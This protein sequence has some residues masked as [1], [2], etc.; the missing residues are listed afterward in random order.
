MDVRTEP[1]WSLH[2]LSAITFGSMMHCPRAPSHP[3]VTANGSL[4]PAQPT[5]FEAGIKSH[6]RKASGSS[7][8]FFTEVAPGLRVGPE[9]TLFS[10]V[11]LD[12]N[13]PPQ[14]LMLQFYSKDWNHRAYWGK[15]RIEHGKGVGQRVINTLETSRLRVNGIAWK[16]KPGDVGLEP[17]C[18]HHQL[19][20]HPMPVARCSGIRRASILHGLK[21]GEG[22]ESFD[23]WFHFIRGTHGASLP[24]NLQALFNRDTEK[25]G[26]GDLALLRDHFL[27]YESS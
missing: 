15:D 24:D 3:V 10:W 25:P 13:D 11:Y 7:Q 9:D 23:Q 22:F 19:G 5:P 6:R 17:E 1:G 14:S 18:A 2:R 26:E 8:H 12:P 27:R 21:E 4:S 16:V 20:F